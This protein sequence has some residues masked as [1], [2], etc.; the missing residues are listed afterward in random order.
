MEKRKKK[1]TKKIQIHNN[2]RSR[3]LTVQNQNHIRLDLVAKS[4]EVPKG[5][6]G[7]IVLLQ[8]LQQSAQSLLDSPP[9]APQKAPGSN[10][11]GATQSSS[12]SSDNPSKDILES[13][14]TAL[15]MS[16]EVRV[17]SRNTVQTVLDF[18]MKQAETLQ[19]LAEEIQNLKKQLSGNLS[20]QQL[21]KLTQQL[22]ALESQY[23]S[24]LNELNSAN[25]DSHAKESDQA[26]QEKAYNDYKK[27]YD[28]MKDKTTPAAKKLKSEMDAAQ[29][30]IAADQ[31]AISGD[32]SKIAAAQ[33]V[34]NQVSS[35]LASLAKQNPSFAAQINAIRTAIEHDLPAN[36]FNKILTAI[37]AM[38]AQDAS[39]NSQITVKE[40]EQAT[41]IEEL[42]QSSTLVGNALKQYLRDNHGVIVQQKIL[43]ILNRFIQSNTQSQNSTK[44]QAKHESVSV[45][46]HTKNVEKNH[47]NVIEKDKKL[48]AR[49][50][51]SFV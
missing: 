47:E 23:Q 13:I 9:K 51:K 31:Q 44:N 50:E 6:L 40:Q 22:Q 1:E 45:V 24:A 20:P 32:K 34:I 17:A 21:A 28:Q 19:S 10:S 27:Q 11:L 7:T 26:N 43:K 46:H 49:L 37:S 29:S 33:Q 36:C 14:L 41:L 42:S 16:F 48:K 25:A 12:P 5:Q 18:V 35:S 8:I 38:A 3:A 30:K 2:T 15:E 4:L 39:L